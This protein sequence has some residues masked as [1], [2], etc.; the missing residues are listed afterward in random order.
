VSLQKAKSELSQ[1]RSELLGFIRFLETQKI[2]TGLG[3]VYGIG[4]AL[5]IIQTTQNLLKWRY[6]SGKVT[7]RLTSGSVI[8]PD[9]TESLICNFDI[10]VAGVIY[11]ANRPM[12]WEITDTQ[13]D[14][15][16]AADA[17]VIGSGWSQFWHLDTHHLGEPEDNPPDEVHPKFHF[18]FGGKQMASRRQT[19]DGCWGRMLE[20]HGPRFG[21]PPMDL[22]LALDFILANTSGALWKTKFCN[23]KE[24]SNAVCMSQQRFWKP[25]KEMLANFYNTPRLQKDKHGALIL[26]P[27]LRIESI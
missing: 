25:Y 15:E 5:K 4:D 21:H 1:M 19:A 11:F 6:T 13:M 27:T 23:T 7:L 2:V 17:S 22:I 18:H 14:L 20:M 9:N 12:S 3:S 26:W 10:E 8:F 16:F 24:Y